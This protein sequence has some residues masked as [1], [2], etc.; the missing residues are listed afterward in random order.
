VSGDEKPDDSPDP[1]AAGSR[2]KGVGKRAATI[3]AT[4]ASFVNASGCRLRASRIA[5]YALRIPIGF[6][7]IQADSG[8]GRHAARRTVMR[9][10]PLVLAA[11]L[12]A[13][14]A[15]YFLPALIAERRRR[16]DLLIVA[17]F[18]AVLG[19]TVIGWLLALFWALQRN[20]P[21][22]LA[23]RIG[24]RRRYLRMLGFSQRLA[25]HVEEREAQLSRREPPGR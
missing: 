4:I 5:R 1:A 24:E 9:S 10:H 7:W 14:V 17:L 23:A 21:K 12:A 19:W 16:A 6:E 2:P 8:A 11:A 18:N 25:R 3:R 13:A 15:V 22:D 20:P